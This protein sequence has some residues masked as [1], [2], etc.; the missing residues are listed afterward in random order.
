MTILLDR[1]DD[2]GSIHGVIELVVCASLIPSI[3]DHT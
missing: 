3:S 1:S 2:G